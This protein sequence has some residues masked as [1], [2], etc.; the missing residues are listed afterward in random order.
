MDFLRKLAVPS[1]IIRGEIGITGM[2]EC[3]EIAC[4]VHPGYMLN[5]EKE[6]LERLGSPEALHKLGSY[7]EYTEN[8]VQKT[9]ELR[10]EVPIVFYLPRD[11]HKY[12]E[13]IVEPEASDFTVFTESGTGKLFFPKMDNFYGELI[14]KGVGKIKLMGEKATYYRGYHLVC[15]GCVRT[16]CDD[17]IARG[18]AVEP[19]TECSF[20][21]KPLIEKDPFYC[22]SLLSGFSD[23]TLERQARLSGS[24]L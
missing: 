5:E 9:E 6:R 18:F 19:V 22:K 23:M 24:R 2:D 14:R 3:D 10:Y 13:K 16:A 20:P 15:I 8:L 17:F 7:L 12:K 4:I 21:Q 11:W 1:S